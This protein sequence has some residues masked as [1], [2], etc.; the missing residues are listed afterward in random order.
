[1]ALQNKKAHQNAQMSEYTQAKLNLCWVEP[2]RRGINIDPW[3]KWASSPQKHD[4]LIT[5]RLQHYPQSDR[6]HPTPFL[7]ST[8]PTCFLNVSQTLKP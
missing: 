3:A 2:I 8:H 5:L 6:L 4:F 7:I 1:M